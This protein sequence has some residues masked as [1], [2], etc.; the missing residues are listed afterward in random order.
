M[1]ELSVARHKPKRVRVSMISIDQ[2]VADES[3]SPDFV[4]IDAES[5]DYEILMGMEETLRRF[6]PVV[7]VEVG[8]M[9]IDGVRPSKD[10]VRFLVEKGYQ[11]YEH[12]GGSIVKHEPIDRYEYRDLLFLPEN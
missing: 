8:D 12:S 10:I 6:R 1:G 9:D 4:K 11:P 2:Y 7:S 5:A 3:L